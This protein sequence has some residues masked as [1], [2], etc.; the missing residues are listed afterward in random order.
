M[1]VASKDPYRCLGETLQTVY[2]EGCCID[3][4]GIADFLK[5]TPHLRTL[6]YSHSTSRVNSPQDWNICKFV[7]AIE[8]EV[9]SHLIELSISIRRLSGS[10][11]PGK[12]S[13]RGFA[14]LQRLELPLEIAICG[15]SAAVCEAGRPAEFQDGGTELECPGPFISDLVPASLSQLW[16]ISDGTVHH[17]KTLALLFR[18][19][20]KKKESQ[21]P[22]LKEIHLSCRATADKSYRDEYDKL[23]TETEKM[24]VVLKLVLCSVSASLAM[25]WEGKWERIIFSQIGLKAKKS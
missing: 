8:R 10:L 11:I 21:M 14:R 7:A 23:L 15:V 19:F 2:L 5:H 22:A 24:G 25:E 6:E 17:G 16:L 9:G 1:S 12:A 20:A 4:V 13:M 18:Q 3:E